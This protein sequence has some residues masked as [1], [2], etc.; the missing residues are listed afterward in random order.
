MKTKRLL[1]LLILAGILTQVSCGDAGKTPAETT[2]G[3]E[4]TFAADS[5]Y[6]TNGFLK[7]SL[8]S[9]LN[10]EGRTV[11]IY[12][13]GDTNDTEFDAESTGD[14]V[15]DAIYDRNRRIEERLGV[16]LEY[17]ANTSEDFWGD[18]N[19]Y[20]D[21]VRAAVLA[22]DGSMDIAVGLSNIMPS[23][24]QSGMFVNLLGSDMKYLDFDKPWWPAE[25]TNELAVND[26][27]YMASG[28]G[29]LGVIKGMMCFYFNKDMA[30]DMNLGDVY[31]LV[32]D[33]K[34]TLDKLNE[35]ASSAYVD[36]NGNTAVDEADQFGFLISNV[37]HAPNFLLASGLRLTE[38]DAAGLPKYALGTDKVVS[39]IEKLNTM[40]SQDSFTA[41][42]NQANT[43][44]K[45]FIDGHVLFMTGEFQFAETFRDMTFDFGILPY[46]KAD[47]AQEDYISSS[48]ATY[49]L[50]GILTTADKD[51]CAAVLEAISSENYRSVTP[52]YFEKALKVKYSRDDTSSQMFDLIKGHISFDFGVVH[53]PMM[54]N[55]STLLRVEICYPTGTWV[56]T[57]ASKEGAVNAAVTKYLDDIMSLES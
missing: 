53:G 47:E 15:D 26:R 49:S 35:L 57:W 16:K 2:K 5:P 19:I 23:L 55:I 43:L 24:A 12:T 25:L 33:G 31:S 14:I 7:D 18:R 41:N 48:R 30:G 1:A 20:M 13:R 39:L 52:A 54:E 46:P 27:M 32:T 29:C 56:S 17:F 40:M 21:T 37:N 44:T 42:E 11:T 4:T 38:N 50:F 51:D 22:N 45:P 9:D 10:L 6:D 36:L 8:P 34:W 28:E 3:N